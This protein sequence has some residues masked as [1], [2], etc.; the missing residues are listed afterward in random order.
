MAMPFVFADCSGY[1]EETSL[2]QYHEKQYIIVATWE[3]QNSE[4]LKEDGYLL[5]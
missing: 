4:S 2:D 5:K 3:K 1:R